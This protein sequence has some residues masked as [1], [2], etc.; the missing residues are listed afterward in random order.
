MAAKRAARSSSC[1]PKAGLTD[2]TTKVVRSEFCDTFKLTEEQRRDFDALLPRG[3]SGPDDPEVLRREF[4][5][6]VMQRKWSDL[7]ALLPPGPKGR[8]RVFRMFEA[9]ANDYLKGRAN[10]T[11]VKDHRQQL[12]TEIKALQGALTKLGPDSVEDKTK[13][14]AMIDDRQKQWHDLQYYAD[15]YEDEP[16]HR[17]EFVLNCILIWDAWGGAKL[18]VP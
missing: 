17:L 12:E 7:D 13:L 1:G 10:P 6:S 4:G 3:S 9:A 14:R 11:P 15:F 16:F 2:D 18:G 8:D 5:D